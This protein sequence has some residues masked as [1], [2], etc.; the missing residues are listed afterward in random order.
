MKR[1]I[2]TE[3]GESE[4]LMIGESET[5]YQVLKHCHIKPENKI[6]YVNGK[7]ISNQKMNAPLAIQGTIFISVQNKTYMRD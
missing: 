4:T 6:V 1:V 7:I 2:V 3:D 5:P